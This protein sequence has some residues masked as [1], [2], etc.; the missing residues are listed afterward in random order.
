MKGLGIKKVVVRLQKG[1][2]QVIVGKGDY[3][4]ICSKELKIIKNMAIKVKS[5]RCLGG[6]YTDGPGNHLNQS[7]N[8]KS[9]FGKNIG[10]VQ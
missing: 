4:G 8:E 3:L 10:K 9:G 2:N 1:A 7:G 6:G 5:H